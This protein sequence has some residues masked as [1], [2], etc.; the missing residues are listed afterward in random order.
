M[1]FGSLAQRKFARAPQGSW[2][3]MASK[4]ALLRLFV[5]FTLLLSSAAPTTA[6]AECVQA[7][8]ALLAP[9]RKIPAGPT[10]KRTLPQISELR[11]GSYNAYNL[12]QTA[13]GG[14]VKADAK[15]AGVAAVILDNN[16]D[17]V[18]LQEIEGEAALKQFAQNYLKDLYEP[19]IT[20][21]N[22][23]RGIQVAYLVKRDL[24]FQIELI[25]HAKSTAV[26]PVTGQT[27]PIFSRDLPLLRIWSEGQNAQSDEPLVN[28]FGTHFKSKRDGTGD[29]QSR[30]L[31]GAQVRAAS[32][33]IENEIKSSPKSFVMIAGD[34]NGDVRVE[35][36]FDPIKRIL[37]DAFDVQPQKISDNDRITHS[38]HPKNASTQY[39][40]IDAFFV[41][42]SDPALV[43]EAFVYR[44]KDD[45]G[46]VKPLP[47][48]WNDR[49][50]NPSDHF[51]VIFRFDLP[52]LLRDR[53]VQSSV[54]TWNSEL[55]AA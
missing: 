33:I 18:V 5:A 28:F 47:Q 12:L 4:H 42:D 49:E 15:R 39:S 34:F 45:S 13:D 37:K 52:K 3:K 44:Y 27:Q 38:Y 54:W 41:K 1:L 7:M 35:A 17:V 25:S 32:D 20:Q 9:A 10:G 16:L 30:A 2:A 22:D 14:A 24:P 40:Q 8:R 6:L 51:P 19:L 21:G 26:H 43:K 31:R 36:E 11:F 53:G 29:P 46:N 23:G 55:L 50:A 48:T